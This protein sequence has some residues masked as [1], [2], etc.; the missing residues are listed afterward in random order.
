MAEEDRGVQQP[1][2]IVAKACNLHPR[3]LEQLQKEGHIPP[4]TERGKLPLLATMMA[5]IKYLQNLESQ[6]ATKLKAD[7]R[8]KSTQA[9]LR[10]LE[11]A[12]KLGALVQFDA[13]RGACRALG[14][15]AGA[16]LS[17]IPHSVAHELV[18]KT[19]PIDIAR[20]LEL[21]LD[22][23]R[24]KI[25]ELEIEVPGLEDDSDEPAAANGH[26]VGRRKPSLKS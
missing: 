9:D 25:A 12:E 5:Y 3:R 24:A 1:K 7:A 22:S 26:A 21:A 4:S 11:Y 6:G 15:E 20:I 23:A 2:A 10:Q 17:G 18:G 16:I 8:L 13:V 14:V 19:D